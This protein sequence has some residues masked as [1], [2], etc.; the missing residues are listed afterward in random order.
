MANEGRLPL[1]SQQG[2]RLVLE[3]LV[4]VVSVLTAFFLDGWRDDRE[5]QQETELELVNVTRELERN[6]ELIVAEISSLQRGI[7]AS[8]ALREVLADN[9][10]KPIVMVPDTLAW[11]A[12]VWSPSL[13]ASG[14]AV[15][16]LIASGRLAQLDDP[17]LRLGLAGLKDLI[18]DALED[19]LAARQIGLTQLVP[20]I[21][22]V[23]DF[24]RFTAISISFLEGGAG[25]STTQEIADERAVPTFGEVAY[26]TTNAVRNTLSLRLTWFDV[27]SNEQV[28]L[29]AYLDDL[30]RMMNLQIE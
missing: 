18:D 9:Q 12:S 24:H 19:E 8:A 11:L 25:G 26:P 2:L 22:D 27:A 23:T 21:R 17:E 16:A 20:L 4:V 13:D 30:V 29:L 7:A 3:G 5:F 14:G 6:R 15:D 28:R 1:M 10:N